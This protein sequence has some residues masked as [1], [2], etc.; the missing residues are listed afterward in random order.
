MA[1]AP[2]DQNRI[3]AM[4]FVGSDSLT[5]PVEG[6]E[7][8]GRLKVDA[9]GGTAGM[10]N[11]MTTGGDLIYGGASG[12]P[13]RLP[14]GTSGQ[15]LTSN[16]T[17]SAPS[18]S[19]LAGSGDVSKVGTPVD[20]QI[21]VW[22]GDG[23]I[24]GDSQF[25]WDGTELNI[26][27][28]IVV[29]GTVDGRNLS[30]DGSK[31]D[32][33]EVN[34]DVTDTANVTSAGALMDSEITN[35]AQVKSFDSSDYATS[36]QGSLAD[37]AMQNL[38]DDI[39]PQLGGELDSQDNSIGFTMQTATGDGTTTIDWRNGNHFDFTFGAFNET[40]TFTAP[41]KPCVLTLSLKQDSVGSRTATFPASVKWAGGTAPT[42]T[43][44]ANTGYD[45]ISFRYDGT[46][47][48]GVASLDF[49]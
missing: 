29:S 37:S 35:L 11:P 9:T 40:F 38:S 30:T 6:D 43:T 23:T 36:S 31:L 39:T 5:Y 46:N 14:N 22:T 2:R 25:T 7:T 49:S 33:I 34:A 47:Y 45:I 1:Q 24:E 21:A 16:G 48:Y 4:L 44:T 27:G 19:T 12:T 13:T 15:V 10:P 20:N 18:W 3:P 8:T 26:T 42:L 17:T 28:N 32:G 41:S